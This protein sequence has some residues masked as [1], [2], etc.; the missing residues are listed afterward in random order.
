MI[1]NA[2]AEEAM[3][4]RLRAFF[5]AAYEL[6]IISAYPNAPRPVGPYGM[7]NLINMKHIRDTGCRVYEEIEDSDSDYGQGPV[8]ERRGQEWDW[9]WS[10][11]VYARQAADIAR[12]WSTA[13]VGYP[14]QYLQ[15]THL[16]PLAVRS[17]SV[18]RIL[19]TMVEAEFERRAGFDLTV[20]GIALDGFLMQVIERGS[21]IYQRADGGQ[22]PFSYPQSPQ[23]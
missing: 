21:I 19:P 2:V 6:E 7:L 3:F 18:L 15:T 17:V 1:D 14:W 4:S 11:N 16:A 8:V 20:H 9:T 22:Y 5:R 10:V 12:V 13:C 23:Y